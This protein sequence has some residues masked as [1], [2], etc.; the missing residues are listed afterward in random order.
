M[1]E[2]L[3]SEKVIYPIIIIII[4]SFTYVVINRILKKMLKNKLGLTT[5]NSKKNKT[6]IVLLNSLIKYILIIIAFIAILNVYGINTS[7]LLASV[8]VA[9]AVAA[10]AF[11]D[12]LK[13]FL[14][15]MFIVF[16]NQ[17]DIGDVVTI[18]GFKGEVVGIGLRTTKLK[19][20]T[21]EHCFIANRNV[22]DIINH[23]VNPVTA[24]VK[25][26]LPYE[27]KVEKVEEI[28]KNLCVRLTD[29]LE[30]IKGKVTLDGIDE[31][32]SSGIVFRVSVLTTPSRLYEVERKIRREIKVE[33]DKEN[34]EIPYTQVVVH[35]E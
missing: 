10:L 32:E 14:A 23:S 18:N 27:E 25:V 24:I 15:G 13:D 9:S 20:L 28:L 2:V 17:Y 19:A 3:L 16:E 21:G 29:E 35:G 12:T 1:L 31:F 5:F 7:S 22:G 30:A 8:G 6:I 4:F 33:L 26:Q 11:Q 34:I